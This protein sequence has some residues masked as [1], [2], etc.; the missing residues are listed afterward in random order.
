MP[1]IE[2]EEPFDFTPDAMQRS[3]VRYRAGTAYNVTRECVAK[4]EKR[5]V[6]FRRVSRSIWDGN[7]SEDAGAGT[8]QGAGSEVTEDGSETDDGSGE[9][10]RDSA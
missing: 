4:A 1:W 2:F 8:S 9:A 10:E 6:R 5:G 3:T 7:V